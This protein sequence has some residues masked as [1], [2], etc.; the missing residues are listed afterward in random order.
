MKDY[1]D[2]LQLFTSCNDAIDLEE[3]KMNQ[4]VLEL[5]IRSFESSDSRVSCDLTIKAGTGR[6]VMFYFTDLYLGSP[7]RTERVDKACIEPRDVTGHYESVPTGMR[8]I[9]CSQTEV[10]IGNRVYYTTGS[11]LSLRF[12]R[13]RGYNVKVYFTMVFT[14]FRLGSCRTSERKC[15]NDRCIAHDIVCNGHNPC[16]DRSDCPTGLEHLSSWAMSGIVVLGLL[17][18]GIIIIMATVCIQRAGGKRYDYDDIPIPANGSLHFDH[19]HV[20]MKEV[21]EQQSNLPPQEHEESRNKHL[22]HADS[23]VKRNKQTDLAESKND[24]LLFKEFQRSLLELPTNNDREKLIH[25]DR[26]SSENNSDDSFPSRKEHSF[27]PFDP[28]TKIGSDADQLQSSILE[29]RFTGQPSLF[30]PSEVIAKT[31]K[32]DIDYFQNVYQ[33]Q[34]K[35]M[36]SSNEFVNSGQ[37]QNNNARG[38]AALSSCSKTSL[39]DPFR[40]SATSLVFSDSDSEKEDEQFKVRSLQSVRQSPSK[41]K[42][43]SS[44]NGYHA[45]PSNQMFGDFKP[46]PPPYGAYRKKLNT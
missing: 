34:K 6:H 4:G 38:D 31:T 35:T 27:D 10:E 33:F 2:V 12:Y 3:R 20:E 11:A 26:S 14:A 15:N 21:Q 8:P 23:E 18:G 17:A 44:L 24:H 13:N 30:V 46:P 39:N 41:M 9:I 22:S 1:D 45:S 42:T 7:N 28:T 37:L 43:S 40:I 32:R 16:G 29:D 25:S 36:Q 19:H 5:T